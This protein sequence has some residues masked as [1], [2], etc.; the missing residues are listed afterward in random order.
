VIFWT[1]YWRE[2]RLSHLFEVALRVIVI[3]AAR[4]CRPTGLLY[5]GGSSGNPRAIGADRRYWDFLTMA[6]GDGFEPPTNGLTASLFESFVYNR[7]C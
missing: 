1:D 7:D 3:A 5:V 2:T 6:P 4:R